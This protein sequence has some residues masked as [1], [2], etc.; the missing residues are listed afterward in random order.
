MSKRGGCL[1]NIFKLLL[2]CLIVFYSAVGLTNPWAF[3]IGGRSTPFLY[4]SGFGKLV[5]KSGTYPLYV[6]FYPSAHS[7]KL[8]LDGLRPTSGLQGSASLCTA[9]GVLENLKV[10]GTVYGGWTSTEGSVMEFR[11]LEYEIFDVGQRQGYFD[12]FGRFSGPEL[13]MDDRGESSGKFR[14]GLKIEHASVTLDYGNFSD[15]KKACS[16]LTNMPASP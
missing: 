3:H 1:A 12:L 5:T 6:M 10:R 9:P 13:V 4:W 8:R 11:L 16:S 7:S 14:S 2:L 15:F